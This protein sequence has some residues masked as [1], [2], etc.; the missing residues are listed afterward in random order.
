MLREFAT[1][2]ACM[3]LVPLPETASCRAP[4]V[5]P[6]WVDHSGMQAAS[7]EPTSLHVE[8]C[9]R[10]DDVISIENMN[11]F[12]GSRWA[13]Q[14]RAVLIEA[15]LD[16]QFTPGFELIQP[17]VVAVP[18]IVGRVGPYDGTLDFAG[19]SAQTV[20]QT[21]TTGFSADI[22]VLDGSFFT[23][24]WDA[25]IRCTRIPWSQQSSLPN[26]AVLSGGLA[27]AGMWVT[28]Q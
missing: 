24:P 28:Y 1:L 7:F 3:M 26:V 11:P 10:F 17:S 8:I 16:P 15:S 12:F 21:I 27:G 22:P 13:A 9:V 14:D 18:N 25:Y 19:A 23:T 2:L 5:A 6:D 20:A 4:L